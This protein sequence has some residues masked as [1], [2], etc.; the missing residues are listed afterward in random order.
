MP[1]LYLNRRSS[2]LSREGEHLLV[3]QHAV[4]EA[5]QVLPLHELS[6][7]VVVGE[8]SITFPALFA[9]MKQQIPVTFLTY[10]G[11]WRDTLETCASTSAAC[12]YFLRRKRMDL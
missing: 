10:G 2:S 9:L 12:L 8:P 6:S 11:K 5:S 1:T 4:G 7:V 3:K